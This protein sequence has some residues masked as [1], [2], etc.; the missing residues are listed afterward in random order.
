MARPGVVY[1]THTR[2]PFFVA[3]IVEFDNLPDCM[4]YEANM[5]IGGRTLLD[6]KYYVVDPI[7]ILNKEQ[8][9]V[10]HLVD[11][12]EHAQREADKMSKLFRRA[13]DW[14]HS[15]LKNRDNGPS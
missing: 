2:E 13:A 10:T 3:E 4:E 14:V 12:L 8:K 11:N 9:G 6:G 5:S 7:F 15:Y 1:L